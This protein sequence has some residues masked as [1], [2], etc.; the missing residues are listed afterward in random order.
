G[1]TGL[2]S[3]TVPTAYAGAG[4]FDDNDYAHVTYVSA[5]IVPCSGCTSALKGTQHLSPQNGTPGDSLLFAFTGNSV[6][7]V[8]ESNF[9]G[10]VVNVTIDSAT[11]TVPNTGTPVTPAA[12][13]QYSASTKFQQKATFG[14]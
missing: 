11:P 5:E 4:T 2:G 1:V 6:T 3:V 8:Y 13:D 10:G 14:G 7:L 9:D 12:L